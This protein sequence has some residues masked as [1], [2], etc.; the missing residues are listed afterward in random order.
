[1]IGKTV[2]VMAGDEV[3]VGEVTEVKDE[4]TVLVKEHGMIHEVD[5]FDIRY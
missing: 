4:S 3:W 5:I 1:M 2:N